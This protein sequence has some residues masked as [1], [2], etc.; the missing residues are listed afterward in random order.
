MSRRAHFLPNLVIIVLLL[1]PAVPSIGQEVTNPK[2]YKKSLTAALGAFTYY[3]ELDDPEQRRRVNDIGYELAVVSDFKEFPFTFYVVDMPVPNA[4]ALPGG[5]IFVTR[6]MLNLGLTDDMLACLLGHELAHVVYKHGTR[7]QRRA[8]LFNTLSSALMLGVLIGVDDDNRSD[9]PYEPGY[10]GGGSHKGDMIQGTMA[11]GMAI[12][13]LLLRNYSREF[14][15]EA[16]DEG[17]RLAAAAGF[18]PDGAR[19][20]WELMNSRLPQSKSYGYWRT[21]PFS[22]QRMRAAEVRAAELKIQKGEPSQDYRAAVQKVIL[23]YSDQEWKGKNKEEA[24]LVEHFLELSALYA[25]PVGPRA[26]GIRL[27]RLHRQRD[28]ELELSELERDYGK[29]VRSYREQL[30]EVQVLTPKSP[31]IATL[32][33]ELD[34]LREA[35]EGLRPKAVAVWEGEIYQTPFLETFLSNYPTAPQAAD[36]ALVLGNAY[37]RLRRQTDAVEQFLRAAEAGPKSA[38]ASRAVEGLR[39]L[40]PHL[41]RLAALARLAEWDDPKLA[42]IASQRLDELVTTFDDLESG[43]EYL[44]RYPDGTHIEAVNER[45]EVL[46][47]NLYGEVVLYQGV[48][49]HVKALERIQQILTHA[50]LTRAAEMLREKAVFDS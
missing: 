11:A 4:F 8:A 16:D 20:L 49:D 1:S 21:H 29:L 19:A 15:D 34:G 48:G 40:A 23:E 13:E 46:A 43:S 18:D 9:T 12:S 45:L 32:E 50:P 14:E 5:H 24:E 36:V 27:G 33:G 39:N 47:K 22:D 28:T 10:G 3:G 38:A 44:K 42:A 26:E 17:Q 31:F 7:M 25:R 6:G 37:S 30:D 41:E 35:A 2:L